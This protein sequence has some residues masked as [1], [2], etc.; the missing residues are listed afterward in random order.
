MPYSVPS[1]LVLWC[2]AVWRHAARCSVIPG[3]AELYDIMRCVLSYLMLC[4]CMT[5]CNYTWCRGAGGRYAVRC[6]MRP[7][8]HAAWRSDANPVLCAVKRE[9]HNNMTASYDRQLPAG[10]VFNRISLTSS[11]I[12][13]QL[14]SCRASHP[15]RSRVQLNR[16][17]LRLRSSPW[18]TD[19]DQVHLNMSLQVLQKKNSQHYQIPTSYKTSLVHKTVVRNYNYMNENNKLRDN[20]TRQWTTSATVK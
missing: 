14:L 10:G 4:C 5:S 13:W 15:R 16:A 19:S 18:W 1:Y 3:V 20:F 8:S 2:S 17:W 6:C 11:S 9:K 7:F 12:R